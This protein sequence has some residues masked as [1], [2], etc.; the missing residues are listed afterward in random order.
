M[1]MKI[2][3]AVDGS[4]CTRMA[5]RHLASRIGWFKSA[6]E[7]HIVNV[8]PPIPYPRADALAALAVAEGELRKAGIP[9]VACWRVGE[10]AAELGS[11]VKANDVDLVV[12]GS[13][14]RSALANVALG[15]VATRCIATL[16]V[17]VMIVRRAP[18]PKAPSPSVVAPNQIAMSATSAASDP[19]KAVP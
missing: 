3:L 19:A 1:S 7:L 15:S 8:Q 4:A 18:P 9:Y 10:I 13:H 11:Y 16:E 14:G 12:M 6:P 2:V 5:A 17:P